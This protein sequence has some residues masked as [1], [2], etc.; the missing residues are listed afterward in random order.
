LDTDV[1]TAS[2]PQ[3]PSRLAVLPGSVLEAEEACLEAARDM[4][5]RPVRSRKTQPA[6]GLT[7]RDPAWGPF[8]RARLSVFFEEAGGQVRAGIWAWRTSPRS[9]SPGWRGLDTEAGLFASLL[10][11]GAGGISS[12]PT[13]ARRRWARR[14]FRVARWLPLA[15]FLVVNVIFWVLMLL[16]PWPQGFPVTFF[17]Q[18]L[19]IEIPL[20]CWGCS[21]QVG[22]TVRRRL[23]GARLMRILAPYGVSLAIMVVIVVLD[24]TVPTWHP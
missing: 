23:E 21:L 4:G 15:T 18:L 20:L 16:L 12:P 2:P 6:V 1:Q 14:M 9:G 8:S 11:P 7:F 10:Q 3:W 13:A 17:D 5:L 24:I 22:R 19:L